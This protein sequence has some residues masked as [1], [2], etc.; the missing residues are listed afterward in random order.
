MARPRVTLTFDNGP[1]SGATDRVLDILGEAGILAS[2]F[3]IASHLDTA[4]GRKLAERAHAEGHWIGNH[5]LTHSFAF[6]DRPHADPAREI[7]LA[8]KRIGPLACRE[9]LFRPFGNDGLIGPHLLSPAARDYLLAN[10][11]TTVLWN[12]VPGDWRDQKGWVDRGLR[13]VEA[14]DWAV[15]V[16]HDMP[17]ASAPRL[18]EFIARLNDRDAIWEQGFP[19][20]VILTRGGKAVSLSD[21]HV[22]VL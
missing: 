10:D 4:S 7:G 13:Q 12:A 17:M 20:E 8:E 22:T 15:V 19:D 3:V 21:E 5:T 6:G 9:K 18:K 1:W 14:R 11:Y 2:F 16:L